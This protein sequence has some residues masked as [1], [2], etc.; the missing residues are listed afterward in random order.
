[1]KMHRVVLPLLMVVSS[2]TWAHAALKGSDP[3]D[4][5]RVTTPRQVELVFDESVQLT[6][7]SL[8]QGKAAAQPLKV[9]VPSDYSFTVPLPKLAPGEYVIGWRVV[10]DD[11]HVSKGEIH[12]TVVA[13]QDHA[14]QH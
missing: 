9:P 6:S 8:Q 1:M 3:A 4:K 11:T 2:P 14:T 12:F 10:S 7:L 13:A 5:S